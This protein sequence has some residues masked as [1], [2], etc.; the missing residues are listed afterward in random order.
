MIWT[1]M[2]SGQSGVSNYEMRMVPS[3]CVEPTYIQWF[4]TQSISGYLCARNITHVGVRE[5]S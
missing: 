1:Q 4:H 5:A 3:V 2:S